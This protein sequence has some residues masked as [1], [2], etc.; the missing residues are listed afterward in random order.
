MIVT[1]IDSPAK[2]D[3]WEGVTTTR[4]GDSV[5]KIV[6]IEPN[7]V[8]RCLICW[9]TWPKQMNHTRDRINA[10]ANSVPLWVKQ[11][12]GV[13]AEGDKATLVLISTAFSLLIT[14]EIS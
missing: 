2:H 3:D 4:T 8:D 7:S 11:R 5:S 12:V 14:G 10:K 13:T 6:D 1:D 9:P